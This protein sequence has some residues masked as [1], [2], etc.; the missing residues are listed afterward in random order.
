MKFERE[1]PNR[2]RCTEKEKKND[3]GGG[4]AKMSPPRPPNG[5]TV[6]IMS[7]LTFEKSRKVKIARITKF[8]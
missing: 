7:Q 8:M 1:I 2:S 4:G 3:R 6:K 5:I